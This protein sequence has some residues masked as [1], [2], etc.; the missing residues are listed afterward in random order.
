MKGLAR[1]A[2]RA[3]R[4]MTGDSEG[5]LPIGDYDELTARQ[6]QGRLTGLSHAELRRIAEHERRHGNRKTV[7]DAIERA[8]SS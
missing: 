8:L 3:R 2:D 6:V 7:L 5:Q 1:S 4:S